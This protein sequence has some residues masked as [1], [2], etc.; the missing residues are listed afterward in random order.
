MTSEMKTMCDETVFGVQ[1]SNLARGVAERIKE[2]F[3]LDMDDVDTRMSSI[4]ESFLGELDTAKLLKIKKK[5]SKT[6]TMKEIT[7]TEQRCMARVWGD[8]TGK[9]CGFKAFGG[10]SDLCTRHAK[11]SKICNIPC[12]RDDSGKNIGLFCGRID[13][14]QDDEEGIMPYK[15]S[16]G[17]IQIR[18]TTEIMQERNQRD[19][20]NGCKSFYKKSTNLVRST[21][22]KNPK[23]LLENLEKSFAHVEETELA[24]V[25]EY[26][27]V[28]EIQDNGDKYYFQNL[29]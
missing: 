7:P 19:L 16:D 13:Q 5:S 27:P 15:D 14:W 29:Y 23:V 26:V 20:D 12:T 10:H 28:L 8:G 22:K 6:S 24:S 3:N 25:E 2:E 21:N 17:K 4:L 11:Q 1:I 18:W 9:Q